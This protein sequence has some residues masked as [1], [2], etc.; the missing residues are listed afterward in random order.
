MMDEINLN[1]GFKKTLIEILEYCDK[2]NLTAVTLELGDIEM[3]IEFRAV[4]ERKEE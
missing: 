2:N 4:A 1:E 3:D